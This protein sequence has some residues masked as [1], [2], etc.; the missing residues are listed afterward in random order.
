MPV[1]PHKQEWIVKPL[2]P[3]KLCWRRQDGAEGAHATPGWLLCPRLWAPPAGH[4][5]WQHCPSLDTPGF[6][7][8]QAQT[9]S[10]LRA[11][12]Q[13]PVA[14]SG[15]RH[16]E[17]TVDRFSCQV[18][19]LSE[20]SYLCGPLTRGHWLRLPVESGCGQTSRTQS[21]KTLHWSS[22]GQ[23][24]LL[25]Q[26][27]TSCVAGPALWNE[28]SA[29]R[30][31]VGFGGHPQG[32]A[33]PIRY[34]ATFATIGGPQEASWPQLFPHSRIID[35]FFWGHESPEEQDAYI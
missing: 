5:C 12:R 30:A 1:E 8:W 21:P 22:P 20:R 27:S 11:S 4:K 3:G 32:L 25:F 26:K 24:I 35:V 6:F 10:M 31:S 9:N 29:L 7:S 2:L 18:K 33:A 13:P 16:G 34:W 19:S 17:I 15:S 28:A 14:P 23:G